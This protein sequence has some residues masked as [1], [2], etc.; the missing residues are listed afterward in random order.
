MSR[1]R[2][3]ATA[4][5]CLLGFVATALVSGIAPAHAREYTSPT[6]PGLRLVVPE[7]VEL[8]SD[9][10]VSGTGWLGA[11][12]ASVIGVLVDAKVSGDPGTVFTR[13][14]VIDPLTGGV[15][16][17]KRLHAV[18]AAEPDGSWR[19]T[20][21]FPTP[22]N[23]YSG[24]VDGGPAID[25]WAVGGTHQLRFLTGSLLP[26]D[27]L[28]SLA[29][30]FVVVGAA[31]PGPHD[32]PAWPHEELRAEGPGGTPA[33]TVWVD[34]A[35]DAAAGATIRLKGS[36]WTTADGTGPSTVAVKLNS[37]PTTQ[38]TRSGT[39]VVEHPSAKGDDTIWALLAGSNP[40]AHPHVLPVRADG[41]FEVELDAPRGL[42]A[43]QYLTVLLQSG[44]F[45]AADVQRTVTSGYLV[46]GS[47][48]YEEEDTST[49]ERTCRGAERA[50]VTVEEP[51]V[52]LGGVLRLTGEGW[53]HPGK[54]R[55]GSVIAVKIDEGAYSRL[56]GDL[57]QNRTIWALVEAD[58]KDGT[59]DV[60]IPLPDGT[61]AGELGSSPRFRKGAHTVRLLS[62]SLKSGD[63][64]RTVRSEEFVVGRY[65]PLG[66]P[67]PVLADN[68]LR[69]ATRGG[70]AAE[71]RGGR[72]H[73]TVPGTQAGDWV[74]LSAYVAD[75]SPRYPWEAT[76]FRVREGGTVVAPLAERDLP[77]GPVR[78]VAQS[79][80][81]GAFGTLLGW[82]KVELAPAPAPRK[83]RAAPAPV[84]PV[85]DPAKAPTQV[86][87][88]PGTLAADAR[89]G[90]HAEV[91]D[92]IVTVTLPDLAPGTWVY[93]YLYPG[94]HPLGWVRLDTERRVVLDATSL[95]AATVQLAFLDVEGAVLGWVDATLGAEPE[96]ETP[97]EPEP[98]APVAAP[99][100]DAVVV[101]LGPAPGPTWGPAR[102][103]LWLLAAAA[104]LLL[105]AA[106]WPRL[107]RRVSRGGAA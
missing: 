21:P 80:N 83:P 49:R 3:R 31:G 93:A 14:D 72:L 62:G 86:P 10:V 54:R 24:Y 66:V 107:G 70:L 33:A 103:D 23:S 56:D 2:R 68:D 7:A 71:V 45:D 63:A 97:P 40:A 30:D 8:G 92:G 35:V 55:G 94:P 104:L 77:A 88:A 43:G 82:T 16:A 67:A 17:D 74:F 57:H 53:C 73:V 51:T 13:R 15:V 58:A 52:A 91:L 85:P 38:Y 65:R 102:D 106:T 44:R 48:P 42:V 26:G 90:A 46:V 79:G 61:G 100:D 34:A 105:G 9:I 11:A 75:G 5:W 60:E 50:T 59:F 25:A 6:E 12:G 101:A 27:T 20:I 47:V 19:A 95:G 36:G 76:W 98:A 41:T 89:S 4:W 87:A 81:Q 69:R 18:V 22:A 1:A 78:L 32:P 96:P 28:R 39:E 99:E 84:A 37:G 64:V 29:A